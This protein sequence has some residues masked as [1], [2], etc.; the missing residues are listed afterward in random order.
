MSGAALEVPAKTRPAL[1]GVDVSVVVPVDDPG[2]EIEDLFRAFSQELARLGRSHEFVFV[3]DG[4]GGKPRALLE[5]LKVECGNVKIVSLA[6]RFGESVALSAGFERASGAVIL[7]APGYLQVDPVEVRRL[8]GAIEAGADF[9]TPWRHPR[10]DSL[11]NRLQ[12]RLFNWLLR[13]TMRISFHDVNCI[14]RAMRRAV[15]EEITVYGDLYRFLPV[16]AERQGFRVVEIRV[17]HLKE[18]GKSGFF[19]FGAYARRILD[20]L[21][22][23]FL[24]KFTH[25]PLRFFG[26]IG[27]GLFL[28]GL[29]ISAYATAEKF[30][31]GPPLRERPILLLGVTLMM[32]GVQI[33]GFGLVGEI[34]IFTQARHLREYKVERIE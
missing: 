26:T 16:L 4:V 20:I 25:R 28:A 21:A 12:S 7:T 2:A 3:L 17:R 24:T 32:L 27:L 11:V 9:V 1:P 13:R 15:L 6:R 14:F 5:A 22:I 19:G 29:G 8:L 10:V 23:M 18:R 34:I 30:L 31:G 33:V